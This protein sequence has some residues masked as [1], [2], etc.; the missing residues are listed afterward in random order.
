MS[1]TCTCKTKHSFMHLATCDFITSKLQ[2]DEE[3]ANK[4]NHSAIYALKKLVLSEPGG[5]FFYVGNTE[6]TT[7]AQYKTFREAFT[8]DQWQ[9][10]VG[11]GPVHTIMF[12]ND[13]EVTFL[14]E[15][16]SINL[17]HQ[18]SSSKILIEKSDASR[19]IAEILMPNTGGILFVDPDT[20]DI[21]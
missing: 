11:V 16:E 9:W 19:D 8:R 21:V 20:K 12:A 5:I 15:S 10:Q 18:P 2:K 17:I 13:S 6:E 3:E 4:N 1:D 7:L 14:P